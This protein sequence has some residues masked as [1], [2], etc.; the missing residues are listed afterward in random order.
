MTQPRLGS[1]Q[2]NLSVS[3]YA[4]LSS[5]TNKFD[6]MLV[7]VSS[8][9]RFYAW[10]SPTQ[11]WVVPRAEATTLPVVTITSNTTLVNGSIVLANTVSNDITITLPS[12]AGFGSEITIKKISNSN[13]LYINTVSNQTIDD[14]SNLTIL[15]KNT[16]IS[17]ISDNSNWFIR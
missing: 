16:S 9:D 2:I 15:F 17:L 8:E 13:K 6:G 7:L 10:D 12:A 14:N 4:D 3:T 1:D 11:T 5:I